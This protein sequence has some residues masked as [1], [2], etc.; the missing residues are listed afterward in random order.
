MSTGNRRCVLAHRPQVL[1]HFEPLPLLRNRSC[2]LIR[3][4][5]PGF[6]YAEN[7]S[8]VRSSRPLFLLLKNWL[9]IQHADCPAMRLCNIAH[10][11]ISRRFAACSEPKQRCVPRRWGIR[12]RFNPNA[13]AFCTMGRQM[14]LLNSTGVPRRCSDGRS[15]R[16]AEDDSGRIGHAVPRSFTQDVYGGQPEWGR[17]PEAAQL[18]GAEFEKAV[19]EPV[20][21]MPNRENAVLNSGLSPASTETTSGAETETLHD[22]KFGWW[23]RVGS[24]YRPWGYESHAL[25]I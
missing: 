23:R 15:P 12:A 21:E 3:T 18:L 2:K 8:S 24:N 17:N 13:S 20:D 14:T 22:Q 19:R 11:P 9:M 4:P 1:F 5:H 7:Q 25:T 6:A 16:P 10:R